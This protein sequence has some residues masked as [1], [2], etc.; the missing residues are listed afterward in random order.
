[1]LK[2]YSEKN[3][4]IFEINHSFQIPLK[5]MAY[6]KTVQNK[7]QIICNK[8]TITWYVEKQRNPLFL[9]ETV[10][11]AKQILIISFGY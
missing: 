8:L 7:I 11:L 3:R 6:F 10:A 5:G 9:M 2:E 4:R 1:M